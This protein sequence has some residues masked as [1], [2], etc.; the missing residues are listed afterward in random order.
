MIASAPRSRKSASRWPYALFALS[1]ALVSTCG[2]SQTQLGT[3]FGTVTDPTGAVIPG[4]NVTVSRVSTGLKRDAIT[5]MKGQHQVMGLPTGNYE[6]RIEKEGFQPEIRDGI[7]IGR[8]NCRKF[9][10]D[11]LC[12]E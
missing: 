5:D 1:V 4:A 10:S 9:D 11:L 12:R 8:C 6:V 2:W 7:A 3:V